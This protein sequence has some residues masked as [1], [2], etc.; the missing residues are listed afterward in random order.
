MFAITGITGQVGGE[1]ARNLLAAGQPV[2]AVVRDTR[3]GETWAKLGC[4]L[5]EA[6]INDTAALTK[7]FKGTAGVFVLVPPNFDPS[8]DFR[9]ARVVAAALRS[10]LDAECPGRVVCLS[11]IRA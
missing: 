10:A 11:T 7:A 8:P 9:E 5:A 4:D 6:D 3:K 2:R 1:V